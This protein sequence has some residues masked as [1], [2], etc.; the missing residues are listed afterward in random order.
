MILLLMYK[1]NAIPNNNQLITYHLPVCYLL[2]LQ[3]YP[4]N[5]TCNKPSEYWTSQ[6]LCNCMAKH[7]SLNIFDFKC[8]LK[9]KQKKMVSNHVF[10]IT[11]QTHSKFKCFSCLVFILLGDPF[12]PKNL[13]R[14]NSIYN[15]YWLLTRFK[16]VRLL[17]QLFHSNLEVHFTSALS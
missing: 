14:H 4:V 11:L 17:T 10:L 6:I 5:T 2:K 1:R 15:M 12:A 9:T 13:R 16:F 8:Y 7:E 3:Q